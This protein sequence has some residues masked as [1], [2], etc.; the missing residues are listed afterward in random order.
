M[1]KSEKM[2]KIPVVTMVTMV[3]VVTMENP[4]AVTNEGRGYYSK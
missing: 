3:P 1:K 2:T 4:E